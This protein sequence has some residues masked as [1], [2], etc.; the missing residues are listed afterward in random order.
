FEPYFTTKKEEGGTGLGL[1]TV[2][3]IVHEH[4]GSLSV[5]SEPG[6]G[7][8]FQVYLPKFTEQ[9]KTTEQNGFRQEQHKTG[10]EHI[11]VVDDEETVAGL[12]QSMLI[13]LGYKVTAK[14]DSLAA[15]AVYEQAP[16]TFDLLIT[17]MAMPHMTGIELAKKV[18]LIKPDFPIILC[19][20]FS[21]AVNE[22]K[23][24]AIGIRE[25]LMKPVL[26]SKLAA[27]VR[28]ALGDEE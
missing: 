3:A 25:Y 4:G 21:E 28:R 16:E 11:L 23:A 22:E 12:I 10:T 24:E 13:Q 20:G 18:L 27:S 19:T 8:T 14:T 26:R 7:T 2:H 15:L 5:Y 9:E 6:I 1:A 17:D